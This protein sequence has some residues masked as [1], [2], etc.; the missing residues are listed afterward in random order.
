VRCA[1]GSFLAH[2]FAATSGGLLVP[3]PLRVA[4][5]LLI[6]SGTLADDQAHDLLANHARADSA[7]DSALTGW[8]G[9]SAAALSASAA[10]WATTTHD[11]AARVRE[12]GAALRFTGMAFAEM[13]HLSAQATAQVHRADGAQ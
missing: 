2:P 5:E 13:E 12:H 3:E 11:L 8:V 1:A 9:R 6:V 10:T 4:A 7:V